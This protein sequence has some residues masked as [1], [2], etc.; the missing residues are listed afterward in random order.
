[1]ALLVPGCEWA[2][3][4]AGSELEDA[5]GD[6]ASENTTDCCVC[7]IESNEMRIDY[8]YGYR[9]RDVSTKGNNIA[10]KE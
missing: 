6:S 10:D 3:F 4:A 7:A 9:Q 2:S 8:E 5:V 1:M